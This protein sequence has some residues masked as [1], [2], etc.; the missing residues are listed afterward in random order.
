MIVLTLILYLWAALSIGIMLKLINP[1][2]PIEWDI[3]LRLILFWWIIPIA[4]P[5][6]KN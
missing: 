1:H 2:E 5:F 6:M 3:W 4:Y